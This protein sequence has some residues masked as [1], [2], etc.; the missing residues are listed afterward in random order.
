MDSRMTDLVHRALDGEC[1]AAERAELESALKSDPELR[2][3]QAQLVELDG[4]LRAIPEEE[5]PPTLRGEI[6]DAVRDSEPTK[7]RHAPRSPFPNRRRDVVFF[8][9]GAAAMFLAGVGLMRLPLPERDGSGSAGTML[10]VQG[11]ES[12]TIEID[13]NRLGELRWA[14]SAEG[15]LFELQWEADA[16]ALLELEIDPEAPTLLRVRTEGR[17]ASISLAESAKRGR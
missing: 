14:D 7:L 17:E 6:L 9:A 13:G 2:A 12:R 11:S 1:N 3:F 15:T 8:V 10:P 16:P 5:L 4:T